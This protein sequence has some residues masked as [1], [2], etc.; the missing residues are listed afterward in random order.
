MLH[1]L[2]RLALNL[3]VVAMLPLTLLS[4]PAS[5]ADTASAA[6]TSKPEIGDFGLDLTT[7]KLSVKPGDDFFAYASGTWYD[8]F[9]IPEDRSSYGSFAVLDELSQKRVREIIEEAAAQ[10]PAPGTPEHKIGDY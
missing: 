5:A 6:S 4:P 10:K 3:A 7:R 8:T 2:S 9:V 1:R